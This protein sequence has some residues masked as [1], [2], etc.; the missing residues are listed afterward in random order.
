ML[1]PEK[2]NGLWK[3]YEAL[4]T[5]LTGVGPILQGSIMKRRFKRPLPSLGGK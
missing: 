2:I 1:K 3:R 4:R 5:A